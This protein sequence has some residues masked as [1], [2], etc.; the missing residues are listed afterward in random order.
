MQ[1]FLGYDF[2]P[3]GKLG[4]GTQGVVYLA[5]R[6]DAPGAQFAVKFVDHEKVPEADRI[7]EARALQELTGHSHIVE[8]VQVCYVGCVY[9][10]SLQH[11]RLM[12]LCSFFIVQ[13]QPGVTRRSLKRTR[14][15]LDPCQRLTLIVTNFCAGQ[16]IT[17]FIVN[18]PFSEPLART[19]LGQLLDALSHAHSKSISH[20]DVKVR[21]HA[22]GSKTRNR[23]GT[24]HSYPVILCSSLRLGY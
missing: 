18:Q 5:T 12:H 16:D 14:N 17:A 20:R 2:H 23:P 8:L 9:A 13:V 19:Y 24:T 7:N 21:Y 4:S 6:R 10:R 11:V 15:G 1:C 22:H 3:D